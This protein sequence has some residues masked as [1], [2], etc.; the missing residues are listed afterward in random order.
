MKLDNLIVVDSFL[1]NSQARSFLVNPSYREYF[2][3][4]AT[5]ALSFDFCLP[6]LCLA[7]SFLFCRWQK[8]Q[9]VL[10][11]YSRSKKSLTAAPSEHSFPAKLYETFQLFK[12]SLEINLR[13]AIVFPSEI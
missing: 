3:L 11:S 6:D 13:I 7:S 5:R 9:D 10:S 1:G 8:W 2:L 12:L 4:L